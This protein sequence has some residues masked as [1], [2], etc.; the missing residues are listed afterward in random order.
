MQQNSLTPEQQ[1]FRDIPQFSVLENEQIIEL[2]RN[3]KKKKYKS[4]EYF[5]YQGDNVNELFF[6]EMGRVEISKSDINGRKLTLWHIEEGGIFCLADLF[7]PKAFANAQAIEDSMIYS[8]PKSYFEKI[9]MGSGELS[10]DLICCMSSKLATYSSLVDDFA[11]KKMEV[12]LAKTLICNFK[13]AKDHEYCCSIAQEELASMV[14]ASREA[15]GRCLKL[16]RERGLLTISKTG[17][18]R[19]I[20]A[21]DYSA[22]EKIAKEDI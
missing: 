14:G 17:R 18:P 12:R 21:T 20:M 8:L 1:F 6:L 3:T 2:A 5:F 16:F 10:R 4:G 22:L 19:L 9:I 13:S 15:V 7:Y 11:F